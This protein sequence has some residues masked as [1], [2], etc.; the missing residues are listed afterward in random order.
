MYVAMRERNGVKIGQRVRDVDGKDLGRVRELHDWGFEV[1][2]GFML[3][4]RDTVARYDEVRG[5][6]DGALVLA[7]SDRD[8]FELAAGGIPASWRV[9]APPGF[10]VAATPSEARFLFEDIAAGVLTSGGARGRAAPASRT[11]DAPP[12][13]EGEERRYVGTRGQGTAA[14]PPA[15]G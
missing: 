6:R 2:K 7:R 13:T 11:G 4:R 12:V 10:P 8:L 9:A 15:L 1:A 14:E 5:E 3:F